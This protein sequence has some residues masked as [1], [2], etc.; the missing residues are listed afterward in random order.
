MFTSSLQYR[1]SSFLAEVW[2]QLCDWL[3][4]LE[5]NI[6][7]FS[8]DLNGLSREVESKIFILMLSLNFKHTSKLTTGAHLAQHKHE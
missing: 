5:Y 6:G 4:A 8:I 2:K 1:R 3:V 7:T